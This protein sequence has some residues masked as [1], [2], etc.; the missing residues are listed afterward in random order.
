LSTTPDPRLRPIGFVAMVFFPMML[1][2][3]NPQLYNPEAYLFSSFVAIAAMILLSVLL[4]TI[5][6]TTGTLRRR[7]YLMSA[8]AEMHAL[9]A[10]GSSRRLDDE[11]ALFRDADRIGQLVTL[12]PAPEDESR[13][14]LRR[15]LEIFRSAAAVRRLRTTLAELSVRTGG[16]FVGDAYSA[17]ADRDPRGL[18]RAAADLASTAGGLN[19]GAR[20]VARAAGLDLVWTA[21]LIESTA[22][23]LDLHGSISS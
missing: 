6:P 16:Q 18:R 22:L 15:V 21:F 13:D 9:L 17:L 12:Q 14:D 20:A 7:W 5:L 23:R 3:S 2:P 11:E 4:Q 1:S 10:S 19:P 8:R